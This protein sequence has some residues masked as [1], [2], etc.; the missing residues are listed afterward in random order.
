[1]ENQELSRKEKYQAH[2]RST[3]WQQ[4]RVAAFEHWGRFCGCCG[5][6]NAV[7]VHHLNYRNLVDC[8][9]QDLMPLC[10]RCHEKVHAMPELDQMARIHGNPLEKRRAVIVCLKATT[11]PPAK[12][13][14]IHEVDMKKVLAF[15]KKQEAK[16]IRREEK[17]FRRWMRRQQRKKE[18]ALSVVAPVPKCSDSGPQ[19]V[20]TRSLVCALRTEKNAFTRCTVEALGLKWSDMKTKGWHRRLEGTAIPQDRYDA[21]LAGRFIFAES[22]K[23]RHATEGKKPDA[24]SSFIRDCNLMETYP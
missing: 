22:T 9:P 18:A 17:K 7:H 16:R 1:M 13:K 21:A 20:L 10:E 14:R 5:A 15:E 6:N 12:N 8:I 24:S 11:I 19:I 4:Q 2:L 23:A 3:L